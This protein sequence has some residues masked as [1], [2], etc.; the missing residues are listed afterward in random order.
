[1]NSSRGGGGASIDRIEMDPLFAQMLDQGGIQQG[2]QVSSSSLSLSM[3]G[4][5]E[6]E[7]LRD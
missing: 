4:A 1:M 3:C 7:E 6:Q 2:T 5:K